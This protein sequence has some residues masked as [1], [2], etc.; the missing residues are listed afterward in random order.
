MKPETAN[1][2]KTITINVN[3]RPHEAEKGEL[4]FEQVVELAYPGD[5]GGELITFTVLYRRG[6]GNK[7]QGTLA[8]GDSV[9]LKDGMLFDVTRT[10]R[11]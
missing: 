4:T 1:E 11:S 7:P 10:D 2:P 3:G 5:P 8:S 9:K 6:T